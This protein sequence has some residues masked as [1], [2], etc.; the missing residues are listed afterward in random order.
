MSW[1]REKYRK[2]FSPRAGSGSDDAATSPAS[3]PTGSHAH[4]DFRELDDGPAPADSE[5]APP[6]SRPPPPR[7]TYE[8][9]T[10]FPP[11]PP[12]PHPHP[13]SPQD[14]NGRVA[15]A[16]AGAPTPTYA[17]PAGSAY[18]HQYHPMQPAPA[19]TTPLV[20]GSDVVHQP[21]PL[22]V[23]QQQYEYVGNPTRQQQMEEAEREKLRC[24][25]HTGPHTTALA[26]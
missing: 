5:P 11:P 17:P 19:P 3:S 7:L 13:P 9:L 16:N 2:A 23:G 6:P 20:F 12:P 1:L 10:L 18:A 22:Q 25:P 24:V 14:L 26:W 4:G 8:Q 21:P 15:M